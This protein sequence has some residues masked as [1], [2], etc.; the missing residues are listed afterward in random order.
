MPV[1]ALARAVVEDPGARLLL[2][3]DDPA[4]STDIP[5]WCSLRGRRLAWT[6]PAPDGVGAAFLVVSLDSD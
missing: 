5:A 4:A 3:S 6:G 1:I 2:L